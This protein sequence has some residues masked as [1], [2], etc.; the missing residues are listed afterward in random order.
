MLGGLSVLRLRLSGLSVARQGCMMLPLSLLRLTAAFQIQLPAADDTAEIEVPLPSVIER[1]RDLYL[2]DISQKILVFLA[3]AALLYFLMRLGRRFASEHI[4]EVNRRHLLRKLIGY[5]YAVLL[6]FLALALFADALAGFGTIVGLVLAGIAVALQDILKSV[7]GWLYI[8]T[9]SSGV[10]IGSRVEV[11]GMTGDV[12]DIGVLKTTLLEIG[13]LVYGR[14]STGR[15]VTVPNYRILSEAVLI[16]ASVNPFV[17]QE[18]KLEVTYESD[19]ERAE[20][21]MCEIAGAVHAEL[22][23][24]VERGF[25]RMERHYAF[26]YGTLTPIVYVTIA[27][28]GVELTLR[29]LTHVRRRRGS[30]DRISRQ[31]LAAFAREPDVE[32]AYPTYRMFRLGEP[33]PERHG[34]ADMY[35]PT[36]DGGT[37]PEG[38]EELLPPDPEEL[39]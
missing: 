4:E 22:G 10:Q 29:F 15:L 24:E 5:A 6:V 20:Q 17:W 37:Q 28:S 21:V 1:W 38:A 7:V 2:H 36:G 33:T 34:P 11:D 23:P 16:S 32:L 9:R 8:S 26:K 13:N 31:I 30:M 3:L 27:A 12:I 25:R 14:Q 19:W 39:S 18:L 35:I